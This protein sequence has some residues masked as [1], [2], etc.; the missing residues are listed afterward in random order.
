M[1]ALAAGEILS[2]TYRIE[3]LVRRGPHAELYVVAH[4]RL[5]RR[6]ALK[7]LFI[8]PTQRAAFAERAARLG[9]L[10][11]P[12]IVEVLDWN[13]TPSG[14]PYLVMELLAGE[15]LGAFLR[16]KP[17]IST[18][19]A[20]AL[21]AQIGAALATAHRAGVGHGALKPSQVFVLRRGPLPHFIKV[22]D[23]GLSPSE[24]I[25]DPQDDQH[26]LATL[27]HEML[28]HSP[29]EQVSDRVAAA[30]S[31]ALQ[32]PPQDRFPSVEAFLD[33]LAIH[34]PRATQLYA[35]ST[36]ASP[37]RS[38]AQRA[39]TAVGERRLLTVLVVAVLA[40]CSA[41]WAMFLFL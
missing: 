39:L 26:A 25:A 33:A 36:A 32:P 34:A 7:R 24:A 17:T 16:R 40:L 2:R 41:A 28:A 31:R 12:H 19:L 10:R 27:L 15:D 21:V 23:L 29:T 9:R 1:S 14:D 35:A 18:K 30:L 11:H 5:P 22:L 37:V 6:F 38:I 8:E 4:T 3:R 20:L 13:Q